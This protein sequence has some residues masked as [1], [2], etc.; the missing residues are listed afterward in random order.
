M[1]TVAEIDAKIAELQK[2]RSVLEEAERKAAMADSAK[3]ATALLA[4]MRACQKEIEALFPGT[5][6]GGVWEQMSP[7]AWP[8]DTKFRRSADL[9]ET[10]THDARERGKKMVANLK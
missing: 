6:E 8:R 10:E 1:P 3:R 9:S 4:A 5:F 7:Q 2:E